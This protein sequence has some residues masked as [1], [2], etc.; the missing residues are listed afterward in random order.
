WKP[1]PFVRANCNPAG[2]GEV[3]WSYVG[4]QRGRQKLSIGTGC[5][6]I[7]IVEH[8]LLHA[9]GIWHEQSRTDRDDYV[10]IQSLNI[11]KGERESKTHSIFGIEELNTPVDPAVL[12]HPPMTINDCPLLQSIF[13]MSFHLFK[14]IFHPTN[15]PLLNVASSLALLD[16][17]TFD[18][19]T[20]CGMEQITTDDADWHWVSGSHE[21]LFTSEID[22]EF[23][24]GILSCEK[25]IAFTYYTLYPVLF[26]LT[27]ALMMVSSIPAANINRWTLA[28]VPLSESNPFRLALRAVAGVSAETGGWAVDDLTLMELSCFPH[29]WH[30]TNFTSILDKTPAGSAI[31]SPRFNSTDGYS[32]Q[33]K[34]YPNGR[35]QNNKSIGLF[36]HLT[37]GDQDDELQWPCPWKQ[38]T[39]FAMDQNSDVRLRMSHSYSITTDP[40]L[41]WDR[42]DKIGYQVD[43]H[44]STYFRGPGYGYNTFLSHVYLHRRQYIRRS[45]MVIL[46]NFEGESNVL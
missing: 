35:Q 16:R 44:G 25:I 6:G 22:G 3:C 28:Q 33:L 39:M 8:E 30:I 23:K 12:D 17:C 27:A 37:S 5:D 7:A 41:Q 24:L 29:I 19:L 34:M 42:P 45:D 9:L 31:Y 18:N 14:I 13:S 11:K 43:D 10:T 26:E 1:I 32:F 46:I 2:I 21:G 36:V 20:I 38:I 4:K 15:T 40:K